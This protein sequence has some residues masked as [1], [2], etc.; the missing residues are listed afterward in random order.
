MYNRHSLLLFILYKVNPTFLHIM[1][2]L[3]DAYIYAIF[4]KANFVNIFSYFLRLTHRLIYIE[5]IYIETLYLSRK[6]NSEL[7]ELS[8]KS[9]IINCIYNCVHYQNINRSILTTLYVSQELN[10][11]YHI[12]TCIQ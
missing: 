12:K 2:R 6:K 7:S 8:M 5:E 9:F 4:R 1:R 3:C 11:C 10:V